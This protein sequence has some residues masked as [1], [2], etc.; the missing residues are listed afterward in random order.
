[1]QLS[2]ALKTLAKQTGNKY[3]ASV[4]RQ[5]HRDIEQSNSLSQATTKHPRAFSP[6]YTAIV[7]TA[8]ESGS[9]ADT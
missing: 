3:L 8:K 5:L 9:L 1:M 7:E 4:I 2:I 6:V